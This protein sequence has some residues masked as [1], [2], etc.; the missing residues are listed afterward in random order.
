MVDK[1][2]R[3]YSLEKLFSYLRLFNFSLLFSVL[4]IIFNWA[5][6]SLYKIVP[7]GILIFITSPFSALEDFSVSYG[8]FY[9]GLLLNFLP[10]FIMLA[11]MSYIYTKSNRL[12]RFLKPSDVFCIG[13][14][15]S[16]LTS[17][18]YWFAFKIPSRGTS[19]IAITVLVYF[20]V[21]VIT[22]DF[23]GWFIKKSKKKYG[24]K[25]KERLAC[26][27]R[28]LFVIAIILALSSEYS[29]L[30][31]VHMIGLII[32]FA[33]IAYLILWREHYRFILTNSGGY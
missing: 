9:V 8:H 21:Y 10:V 17:A 23:R 25:A 16:Y 4:Y 28:F 19:I 11:I 15:S 32:S 14:V 29:F 12:N 31:L 13:I 20:L 22:F 1:K 5:Y 3:N 30:L 33:L 26:T 6:I 7:N 27:T 24:K 2:H 18:I